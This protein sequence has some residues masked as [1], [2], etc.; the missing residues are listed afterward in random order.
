[1]NY[2]VQYFDFLKNS[3]ENNLGYFSSFMIISPFIYYAR[4]FLIRK[5]KKPILINALIHFVITLTLF[6][7]LAPMTGSNEI[8]L[9][10]IVYVI[11]SLAMVFLSKTKRAIKLLIRIL[12]ICIIIIILA[13]FKLYKGVDLLNF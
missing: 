7:V 8:L 1:M 4:L 5:N 9:T 12:P 2:I 6:A 10:K 11:S 13:Y 3:L